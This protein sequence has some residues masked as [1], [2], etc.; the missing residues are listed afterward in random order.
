MLKTS[1]ENVRNICPLVHAI[2]NYVTVNDCANALLAAG[3][4]PIMADDAAE[5][6]EITA[7]CNA[8]VINIGT[9]NQ[10]TVDSML[11]A[12]HEANRLHHPL[13]LDPVGAGAS[14]L[15]T[16]TARRMISELKFSV[17]RGNIS[18]IKTLAIG[19]GNTQGV[20]ADLADQIT[21]ENLPN[22]LPYLQ[23]FSIKTG[24]VIAVSGALDII[25]DGKSTFVCRNGHP[26]MSKIT[27]TGCM[28]SCLCAAYAAANPDNIVGAVATAFVLMGIA[29][30][31]AAAKSTATGSLRAN[32]LNEISS[33][34]AEDL[35]AG[36][37][38]EQL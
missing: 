8:T 31:N 29:G 36:A 34:T 28:L 2:T 35:K 9:L 5:V 17:I 18:E 24:A 23:D 13:I 32:I 25:T 12:G 15:R 37:K 22:A 21:E 30:E 16:D 4:S 1:M 33:L 19:S 38:I 26:A 27:G 20:D 14:K 7:I 3:A 6:A 10:R 11:L